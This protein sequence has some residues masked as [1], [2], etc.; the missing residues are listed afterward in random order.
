VS[1]GVPLV[2]ALDI[3]LDQHSEETMREVIRELKE[4]VSKG[5]YLWESLAAFP[6]IFPKMYVA[7]IKAGE[8]SGSLDVMLKRLSRYLEDADRT[9]KMIKSAM[10]YPVGVMSVGVIVVALMLIFVIPKFE[11]M[12]KSS[13]Q[14]LPA[15]TQFVIDASHFM[16]DHALA[17]IVSTSVVIYLIR[18]YVKTEEGRYFKD[19]LLFRSPLF[20]SLL[21]K[22]G[23][24]RFSRTLQ[25]LLSSGVNII[26]AVDIC[27]DTIDNA[28]LE[29]A[30]GKIR[31]QIEQGKTLGTVISSLTVFPKIAVQMI[32]V[33]ESTGNLDRMLEKLADFY[34]AEVEIL[35][36][37]LSKVVEPLILVMLGGLVGG[38]MI[39]MYL[40]VFKMAGG[41]E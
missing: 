9:A 33:G 37:G 41:I 18:R 31:A 25:T 13:N 1:S 40:P 5:S 19:Q 16:V 23:V 2:Q 11:D 29:E 28:V 38:M 15:P 3:L 24:A 36:S 26:D 20:G 22:G 6:M 30:V 21:Q 10:I 34:E 35:V 4:Q 32:S 8:A 12:L 7:L 14:S 39:A 27:R 17:I